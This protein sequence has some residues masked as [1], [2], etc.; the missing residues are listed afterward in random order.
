MSSKQ[1]KT[2]TPALT[3]PEAENKVLD[4]WQ[5]SHTFD[6]SLVKILLKVITFSVTDLLLLPAR[7][8]MVI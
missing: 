2:E 3:F 1:D 8:T 6:K 4:F 7:L 5:E